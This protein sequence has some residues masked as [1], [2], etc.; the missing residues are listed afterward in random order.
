MLLNKEVPCVYDEAAVISL[1]PL[2]KWLSLSFGVL[3][4]KSAIEFFLM[5]LTFTAIYG[6]CNSLSLLY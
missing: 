5:W 6:V 3:T 2:E 4:F 1:W